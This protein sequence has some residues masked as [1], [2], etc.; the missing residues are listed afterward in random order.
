MSYREGSPGRDAEIKEAF[1]EYFACMQATI[2]GVELILGNPTPAPVRS[3]Y[4]AATELAFQYHDRV[5]AFRF[6]YGLK[7]PWYTVGK[8]EVLYAADQTPFVV[9]VHPE[10]AAV[11]LEVSYRSHLPGVIDGIYAVS[12]NPGTEALPGRVNVLDRSHAALDGVDITDDQNERVAGSLR[13]IKALE[14][15]YAT[16]KLSN[17]AYIQGVL[18][19]VQLL[20]KEEVQL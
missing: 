2:F 15:G 6:K 20:F 17:A 8:D 4:I 16:L 11:R 19:A 12:V 7:Y 14:D 13:R 1:P 9:G 10:T 3:L 18:E 5:L